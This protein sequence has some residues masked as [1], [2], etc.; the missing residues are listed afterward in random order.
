MGQPMA[1]V[2]RWHGHRP[3]RPGAAPEGGGTTFARRCRQQAPPPHGRSLPPRTRSIRGRVARLPV[4]YGPDEPISAVGSKFK[5]R[6]PQHRSDR[7]LA[8]PELGRQVP[9]AVVADGRP[10][11]RLLLGCQRPGA[12]PITPGRAVVM[13]GTRRPPGGGGGVPKVGD[14]NADRSVGKV[15]NVRKR[16]PSL[17]LRML[18]SMPV[19]HESGRSRCPTMVASCVR[20]T[21]QRHTVETATSCRNEQMPTLQAFAGQPLKHAA[22]R[23]LEIF[24]A[25]SRSSPA[26]FVPSC[27]RPPADDSPSKQVSVSS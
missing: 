23:F 9:E 25:A 7:P 10:D 4:A 1:G 6:S 22:L 3:R 15:L 13:P 11:G 2:P 17:R 27:L 20:P 14:R 5:L 18:S 16:P 21:A 24:G 19:E 26:S 12:L 8:H